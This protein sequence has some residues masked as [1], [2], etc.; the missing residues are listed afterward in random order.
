MKAEQVTAAAAVA[1]SV[2]AVFIAWDQAQ[3]MRKQQFAAVYPHI[4]IVNMLS[5]SNDRAEF[6]VVMKNVGVGP[7]FIEAA[8]LT[9]GG[10]PVDSMNDL[11]SR[12]FT[13]LPNA[14]VEWDGTP[15]PGFALAPDSDMTV[16][17]IVW[18]AEENFSK[19]FW[20]TV[21]Q[22]EVAVCYCSVYEKCWWTTLNQAER[23]IETKSCSRPLGREPVKIDAWMK[24]RRWEGL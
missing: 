6:S 8:A 20:P 2:V 23:P 16:T 1:I 5:R 18:R 24:L 14:A 22:T 17:R 21:A 11:V 13:R 12:F 3:I 9:Y 7:A 10:E 15:R 19:T 4:A